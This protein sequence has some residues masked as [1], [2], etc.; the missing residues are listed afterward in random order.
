MQ[1][2]PHQPPGTMDLAPRMP[3]LSPPY[4]IRPLSLCHLSRL[5]VSCAI[6][7]GREREQERMAPPRTRSCRA[8]GFNVSSDE[9][10]PLDLASGVRVP[11]KLGRSLGCNRLEFVVCPSHA[12]GS[13][14]CRTSRSKNLSIKFIVCLLYFAPGCFELRALGR[15]LEELRRVSVAVRGRRRRVLVLIGEDKLLAI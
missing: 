5:T 10:D 1:P 9:G 7:E 8:T 15:W 3:G 4:I 11:A 6:D 2:N 14:F 13:M 12:M